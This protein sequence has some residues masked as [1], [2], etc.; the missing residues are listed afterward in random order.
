MWQGH[1]SK[2]LNC[3]QRGLRN[4]QK[5]AL[6]V[7]KFVSMKQG[8]S[9]Q[10]V[11]REG[12]YWDI[13]WKVDLEPHADDLD[14]INPQCLTLGPILG[15]GAKQGSTMNEV[16]LTVEQW[17]NRGRRGK[18]GQFPNTE[19]VADCYWW[20]YT[21]HYILCLRKI[22]IYSRSIYWF[23]PLGKRHVCIIFL[24]DIYECHKCND[25]HETLANRFV[26][27]ISRGPNLLENEPVKK[28]KVHLLQIQ[29]MIVWNKNKII[30][31]YIVH[32]IHVL[33][34]SFPLSSGCFAAH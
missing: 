12:R 5:Q 11:S 33:C 8:F 22:H 10:G 7:V 1:L 29:I 23:C 9:H 19:K 3:A 16:V 4:L 15:S 13:R 31:W 14:V 21:L 17:G 20:C 27:S 30:L 32:A 26:N 34:I 25:N 24:N 18:K 28:S 6:A 2:N